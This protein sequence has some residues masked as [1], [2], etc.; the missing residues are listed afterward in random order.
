VVAIFRA[1]LNGNLEIG[2]GGIGFP[3][4]AIKRSQ[5]VMN[6]VRFRGSFAGFQETFARVVPPADVHHADA[7]LIMLLGGPGV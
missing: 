1:E 5:G 2:H 6:M 7:A 3:G 4:E